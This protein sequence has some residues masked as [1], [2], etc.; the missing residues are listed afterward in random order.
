MVSIIFLSGHSF[1]VFLHMCIS[2]LKEKKKRKK[3]EEEGTDGSKC[4][5]R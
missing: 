2:F 4:I 1:N 5:V 3:E